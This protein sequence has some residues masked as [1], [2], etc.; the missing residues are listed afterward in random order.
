MVILTASDVQDGFWNLSQMH[1]KNFLM[2]CQSARFSSSGIS[3]VWGLWI[4]HVRTQKSSTKSL[5][6]HKL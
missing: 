6:P 1:W 5:F 2:S 4:Q 3:K